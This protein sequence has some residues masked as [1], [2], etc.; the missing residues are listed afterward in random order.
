MRIG[1]SEYNLN[2]DDSVLVP[3]GQR[4]I[5]RCNLRGLHRIFNFCDTDS[6]CEI[7][8]WI[9]NFCDI[10]SKAAAAAAAM[11][12]HIDPWRSFERGVQ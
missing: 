6:I 11:Q 3:V 1:S 5:S 8:I 2:R 12:I 9:F 10:N 7:C 4:Y